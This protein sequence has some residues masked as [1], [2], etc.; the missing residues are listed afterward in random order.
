MAADADAVLDIHMTQEVCVIAAGMQVFQGRPVIAD[1]HGAWL[2]DCACSLEPQ[3][4]S[5]E[6]GFVTGQRVAVHAKGMQA[7]GAVVGQVLDQHRTQRAVRALGQVL[8]EI[9]EGG[10]IMQAGVQIV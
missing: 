6:F 4:L 9:G 3:V 8:D 1:Q 7:V 2:G 5:G 10:I